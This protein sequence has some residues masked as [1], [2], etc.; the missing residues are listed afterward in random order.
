MAPHPLCILRLLRRSSNRRKQEVDVFH[1]NNQ[2]CIVFTWFSWLQLWLS[3]RGV[4]CCGH[5]TRIVS[6]FD[7]ITCL[8]ILGWECLKCAL[9]W[10]FIFVVVMK[11]LDVLSPMFIYSNW[12][13]GYVIVSK[14]RYVDLI[15]YCTRCL[16]WLSKY[17]MWFCFVS[18]GFLLCNR[19]Y[20]AVIF[21]HFV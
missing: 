11:E 14:C 4:L 21:M 17:W 3:N 8:I 16:L 18:F 2:T 10:L 15:I 20:T 5:S 12:A 1:T 9:H 13:Q 7:R 6:F 19:S